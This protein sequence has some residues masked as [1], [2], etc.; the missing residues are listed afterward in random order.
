MYQSKISGQSRVPNPEW[1]GYGFSKT[2]GN[3]FPQ[4][5]IQMDKDQGDDKKTAGHKSHPS[6]VSQQSNL[7]D[8]AANVDSEAQDLTTLFLQNSL[9]KYIGEL[10]DEFFKL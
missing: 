8:F 10:H 1:A 5:Q 6:L 3:L 9:E 2:H 4:Q 7:L